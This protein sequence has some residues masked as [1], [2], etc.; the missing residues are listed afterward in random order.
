MRLLVQPLQRRLEQAVADAIVHAVEDATPILVDYVDVGGRPTVR[1]VEPHHVVLG[2][3]GSY[4]TGWCRLRQEE[5]VFRIDRIHAVEPLSGAFH[6]PVREVGVEDYETR[7]GMGV[8]RIDPRSKLLTESP[9]QGCRRRCGSSV[10][11]TNTFTPNMLAWFE[12]ATDDPDTATSF[13]ADLF[14]WDFAPFADPEVT[15]MD[16]RVAT[17]P[18]GDAPVRRCR[19]TGGSTAWGT[20][21]STSPSPTLRRRARRPSSSAASS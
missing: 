1:E 19:R 11:M 21:C 6:Q 16:Y 4:V 18:G 20:P 15:G 3:N 8:I 17:L 9:T 10:S 13:Y 12:V 7:A 14:G 2:P 5:R